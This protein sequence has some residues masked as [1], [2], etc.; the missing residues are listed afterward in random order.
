MNNSGNACG[1]GTIRH[2]AGDLSPLYMFNCDGNWI[3][4]MTTAAASTATPNT[5]VSTVTQA[6]TK[7]ATPTQIASSEAISISSVAAV[8]SSA[9]ASSAVAVAT[10]HAGA[11]QT[12]T[13]LST[14]I[15][16]RYQHL[17]I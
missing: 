12:V 14:Y 10:S 9:G 3:V 1:T 5:V 4:T 15:W 16:R 6:V 8:V 2:T 17:S 13:V 11:V 7:T